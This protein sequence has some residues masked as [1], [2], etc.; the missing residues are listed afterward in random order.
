MTTYNVLDTDGNF[1]GAFTADSE[2]EAINKFIADISGYSTI[3]AYRDGAGVE[4][5]LIAE[6]VAGALYDYETGEDIRPATS[7]EL[8]ASIEAAKTDGAGVISVDGRSCYVQGGTVRS[9]IIVTIE[10][11]Q[12]E[13]AVRELLDDVAAQDPSWNGAEF[14]IEVGDY[15][16]ISGEETIAANILYKQLAEITG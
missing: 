1:Q 4:I 11:A 5:N 7:A 3:E 6:E 2:S 9:P 10:D 15:L 16:A 12:H 13:S 8:A 14:E